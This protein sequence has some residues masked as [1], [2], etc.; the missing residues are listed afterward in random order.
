[1]VA[2]DDERKPAAELRRAL[3]KEFVQ[4]MAVHAAPGTPAN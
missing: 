2:V 4:R 1:M 3:R